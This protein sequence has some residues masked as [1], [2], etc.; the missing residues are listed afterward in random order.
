MPSLAARKASAC[1]CE[2][3]KPSPR[4]CCSN[5]LRRR[6]ATS[7]STK[8]SVGW[9]EGIDGSLASDKHAYDHHVGRS[10]P[11]CK[12]TCVARRGVLSALLPSGEWVLGRRSKGLT[13]RKAAQ[14]NQGG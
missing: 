9:E 3:V 2:R 8:P 7:W 5:R 10:L 1:H 14:A 12:A 6:R 11:C 13:K 4:A